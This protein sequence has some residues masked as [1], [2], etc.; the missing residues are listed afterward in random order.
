MIS[1]KIKPAALGLALS[2]C[3]MAM[4]PLAQA[5]D[6]LAERLIQ[7]RGQVDELQTELDLRKEEHKNVWVT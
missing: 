3:C 4:T 1:L 2:A 5:E 7:L 6:T